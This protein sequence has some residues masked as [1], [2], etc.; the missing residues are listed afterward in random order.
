MMK[1]TKNLL[2]AG[3]KLLLAP[4]Q[5]PALSLNSLQNIQMFLKLVSTI[6]STAVQN[7]FIMIFWFTCRNLCI[8]CFYM[9]TNHLTSKQKITFTFMKSYIKLMKENKIL[10]INLYSQYFIVNYKAR[11]KLI[12]KQSTF[13]T[14]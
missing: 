12:S 9:K 14:S 8:K 10:C 2:E 13:S 3:V 5:F 1:C 6:I 4:S 7:I 11:F